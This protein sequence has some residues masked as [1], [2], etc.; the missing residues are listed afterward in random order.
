MRG[1]NNRVDH[2]YFEGKTHLGCTLIVDVSDKPNFHSIDHNY[3]GPRPVLGMNGGE[4]IRVGNSK[5]SLHDSKTTVE[6]NIFQHCDGEAEIISNKSCKNIIRDNLFFESKGSI[7][8]RHGND[9]QVYG[10]YF[11]GNGVQGTGGI[12]II[13]ENHLVYNN[14]FQALTGTGL[15]AAISIM[16]AWENPP[17]HGYW[18]VKN[19]QVIAN[20]II[21]CTEP[22]AIGSGKNEATFLPPVSSVI[23]NNLIL[24]S[25][26]VLKIEESKADIIMEGN[27]VEGSGTNGLPPGFLTRNLRLKSNS[28]I[29]QPSTKSDAIGAFIGKYDFIGSKN[30]GALPATQQQ[31]ALF[32]ARNIGPKWLDLSK[33]IQIKSSI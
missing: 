15:M 26:V 25:G 12:R 7:T 8:L 4:S 24:S 29:Y 19:T 6:Q 18:Q 22:L 32:R 17:L 10:N 9:A 3:F 11:I 5:M 1:F 14:Y 27:L 30:A 2:C 20:T 13:G 28:N 21:K 33:R 16:N 23:A 31:Q